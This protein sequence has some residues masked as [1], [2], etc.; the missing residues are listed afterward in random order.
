[1]ARKCL[2]GPRLCRD[3]TNFAPTEHI[4]YATAELLS[5]E[6][7]NGILAMEFAA[8]EAGEV[9]LQLARRPSGPFL[10]AGKPTEFDWDEPHMRARLKVPAG[11]QQGNRVRIG[12]AI[13]AP[14]TSAFFNDLHRLVIGRK[15][16]IST[17]YSS[18]EVAARSRLR[19]P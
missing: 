8:P 5:I 19:L 14:D 16:T 10:A 12:I 4:V 1:M 18:A 6:F 7:E 9:I 17:M 3:C 11:T 13:E 2:L 15:N